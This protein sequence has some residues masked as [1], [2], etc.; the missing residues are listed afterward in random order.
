MRDSNQAI[1][2]TPSDWLQARHS[3]TSIASRHFDELR[4]FM[5]NPQI[6]ERSDNQQLAKRSVS[7]SKTSSPPNL[8]LCFS[9]TSSVSPPTCF[10]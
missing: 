10:P 5:R 1:K 7:F 3:H 4:G 8:P 9:L 2:R 6:W